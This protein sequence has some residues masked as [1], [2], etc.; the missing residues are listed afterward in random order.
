M[1]VRYFCRGLGREEAHGA[2]PA[3]RQDELGAWGVAF[4]V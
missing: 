4:R 1:Y 3:A 2:N